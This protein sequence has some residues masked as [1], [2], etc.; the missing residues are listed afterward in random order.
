MAAQWNSGL[1]GKFLGMLEADSFIPFFF[2]G[3]APTL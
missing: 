1:E 2:F 3:M